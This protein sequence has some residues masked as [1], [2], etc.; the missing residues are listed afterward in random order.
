MAAPADAVAK[1]VRWL[2]GLIDAATP[3]FCGHTACHRMREVLQVCC[4]SWKD[5]LARVG[6]IAIITIISTHHAGHPQP[7]LLPK[8]FRCICG[9]ACLPAPQTLAHLHPFPAGALP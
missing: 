5:D 8:S 9:E 6:Q 4:M 2:S 1:A 3:H 7:Q